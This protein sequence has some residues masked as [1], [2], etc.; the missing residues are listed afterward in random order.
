MMPPRS[1]VTESRYTLHAME[2]PTFTALTELGLLSTGSPLPALAHTPES[3]DHHYRGHNQFCHYENYKYQFPF[4]NPD[5]SVYDVYEAGMTADQAIKLTNLIIILGAAHTPTMQRCLDDPDTMV[6]VFEPDESALNE[7]LK[8]AKT[9]DL[10]Q[11]RAFFFL[12]DPYSFDPALQ[13]I[14][15]RQVFPQGTPAVFQIAR[16]ADHYDT[17]AKQ[18][19]EYLEILHYRHAIHPLTG[20]QMKY[21]QPLRTIKRERSYPQQLHAFENIRDYLSCPDIRQLKN[22]L[23]GE[24]AILVAAGPALTEKLDY[25]RQNR[26]KAV[27]IAV[28][29]ALKPLV[30]AGIKPHFTVINDT[31][32]ESGEVFRQ[33]PKQPGTIMVGHCLSDLG[34]DRFHQKYLFESHLE[35]I[36]PK[37]DDLELH[38]SVISTA[39]S[40]ARYMGCA[41]CIIV[42]A[43]LASH[44]PWKLAYAKGTTNHSPDEP[45]RPL[46]HKSPQLYPTTTPSGETLYTTTNFR[47]AALWL[48]EVIRLSDMECIN[49]S[50]SS[51]LF[52]KGITFESEPSIESSGFSRAL[53]DLFK[54]E[55]P[56]VNRKL[57]MQHITHERSN[58]TTIHKAAI[59]LLNDN[60]GTML[61]KAPIILKQLDDSGVTFMLEG[62][63][64]FDNRR[65]HRQAL[66]GS[67]SQQINGFH[68]FFDHL[69]KMSVTL[70]D[71]LNEAETAC[72][73]K[74]R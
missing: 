73:E 41:R 21:S 35:N 43:Q 42:G 45:K 44:D 60:P 49:T 7:F 23:P 12:G 26:N 11:Q 74:D 22:R 28:N 71:A 59:D 69:L 46:I 27:V 68:Y 39:F 52:G 20:Q 66:A 6:L 37:R 53:A 8:T 2:N 29:N 4:E 55:L 62:Y 14:L 61:A 16:I 5:L 13:D 34:G 24:T 64:P 33:I 31:S 47:D 15:P 36:F 63:P 1:T 38:G 32:L 65:F 67:P 57:V 54:P 48:S 25:I 58:W 40:L 30:D 50:E 10:A 70:L 19:V 9:K 3:D 51:I 56:R 17:W 72:R 18:T